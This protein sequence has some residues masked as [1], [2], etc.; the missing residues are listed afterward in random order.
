[1]SK[2]PLMHSIKMYDATDLL[3]KLMRGASSQECHIHSTVGLYAARRQSVSQLKKTLDGTHAVAVLRYQSALYA[4]MAKTG[5]NNKAKLSPTWPRV[6]LAI[7]DSK[8]TTLIKARSECN[9]KHQQVRPSTKLIRAHRSC[10]RSCIKAQSYDEATADSEFG[11]STEGEHQSQ[12][13]SEVQS[14]TDTTMTQPMAST[15]DIM[16]CTT[17]RQPTL[18]STDEG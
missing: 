15:T 7:A 8:Y 12:E 4:T 9:A 5:S 3:S 16:E 1:M 10:I 18:P 14:M 6:C 11:H 2:K 17:K 13:A